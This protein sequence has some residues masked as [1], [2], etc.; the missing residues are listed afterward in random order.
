MTGGVVVV[1]GPTGRTFGAGMSGGLAFVV[2]EDGTF[3][4]R[5]NRG[6]VEIEALDAEDEAQVC[7]LVGE[8]VAH[9][10]SV[11]GAD[12]LSRWAAVRSLFKKVIPTEARRRRAHD[13]DMTRVSRWRTASSVYCM[14]RRWESTRSGEGLPMRSTS[15]RSTR[16]SR[17]T[18]S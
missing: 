17:S 15:I 4:S 12:L 1:L 11:R 8:H 9:T 5:C 6:M 2:D 3:A 10:C 14:P 7:T 13:A 18:G 16:S